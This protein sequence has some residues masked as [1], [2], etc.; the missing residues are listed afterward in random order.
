MLSQGRGTFDEGRETRRDAAVDTLAAS[1]LM[2]VACCGELKDGGGTV[3]A[4]SSPLLTS[5]ENFSFRVLYTCRVFVMT[6]GFLH[7]L[8][9]L[10]S[11]GGLVGSSGSGWRGK[12]LRARA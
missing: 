7:S 2:V 1:L 6:I 4:S 3:S 9:F 10:G 12:G 5:P 8:A 11:L